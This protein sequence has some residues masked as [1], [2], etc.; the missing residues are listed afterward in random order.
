MKHLF[1][2]FATA[3]GVACGFGIAAVVLLG[4][5]HLIWSFIEYRVSVWF[6]DWRI[7]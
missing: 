1:E 2:E 3:V 6:D 5:V 7:R 4:I